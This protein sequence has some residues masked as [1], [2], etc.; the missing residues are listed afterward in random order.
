MGQIKWAWKHPCFLCHRKI[1]STESR[2]IITDEGKKPKYFH[3]RHYYIWIQTLEMND[4][5]IINPSGQ[6]IIL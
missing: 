6:K 5:T 4:Q 3:G 1:Y 2:V